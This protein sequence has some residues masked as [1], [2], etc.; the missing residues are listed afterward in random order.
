M[1]G[2][3]PLDPVATVARLLEALAGSAQPLGVTDLARQLDTSKARVSRC[4]ASL[5]Q[6]GLVAQDHATERYHLGWRLFE[7]GERAGAQ[8]D[9]RRLAG[10]VL[11]YLRDRTGLSAVLSVPADGGPVVVAAVDT[12]GGL[13]VTIKPGHRPAPHATAEGRIALAWAATA[14]VPDT[15]RTRVA[16]IR[17]RL[18]DDAPDEPWAG[19]NGLAAPVLRDGD[20]LAGIVSLAGP[21]AELPSPPNPSQLALVH[22]A[23]AV[24]SGALGSSRYARHGLTPPPDLRALLPRRA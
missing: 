12:A 8:F 10:P 21:G 5:K 23:A 7:L 16:R 20:A 1:T 13:G 2:D 22:G 19:L 3:A 17:E 18:W 4:L 15:L 24:L 6:H 14:D 11:T 9:L